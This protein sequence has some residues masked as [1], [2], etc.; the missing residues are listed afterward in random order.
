MRK[1]TRFL[2]YLTGVLLGVGLGMLSLL[3]AQALAASKKAGQNP[4]TFTATLDKKE[5]TAD[6]PIN[7][8]FTLKNQSRNIIYV[9][10]RF[11]FGPEDAAKNEKEVHVT[12]KSPSGQNLPFK[13][14][15]TPGYPKTDYFVMLNPEEEINAEHPRNLRGNFEFTEEGTY[16]VTAVYQNVFG[17]ELGLE[18][19]SERLTAEPLKFTIK[20][21][22]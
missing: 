15:Y 10:K 11:F 5:Y 17:P 8:T 21:S 1:K 22:N 12:I 6:E 13:F 2:F 14:P 3:P 16:T 20:K 18:V 9:N 19:F 4:L 7:L